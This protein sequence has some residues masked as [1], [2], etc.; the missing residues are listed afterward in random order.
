MGDPHFPSPPSLS[1]SFPPFEVGS[2]NS[3]REPGGALYYNCFPS[4]LGRIEPHP[5]S[6]LVHFSLKYGIWW[7]QG[8]SWESTYQIPYSL[9]SIK[10]NRNRLLFCFARFFTNR[11]CEYKQFSHW[12][13]NGEKCRVKF[14]HRT[15]CQILLLMCSAVS[16][17]PQHPLR[18]GRRPCKGPRVDTKSLKK[19]WRKLKWILNCLI[20]CQSQTRPKC[21]EFFFKSDPCRSPKILG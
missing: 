19:F 13:L 4:G 9:N 10:A 14:D 21:T 16:K 2:L 11:Y 15:V 5:K 17:A 1:P 12:Y 3:A 7:Q 18:V 20:M 6:N 8:F